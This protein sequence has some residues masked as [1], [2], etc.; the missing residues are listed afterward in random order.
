MHDE[1]TIL[2]IEPEAAPDARG[3]IWSLAQRF[4]LRQR[5]DVTL[6]SPPGLERLVCLLYPDDLEQR[7]AARERLWGQ[8]IIVIL[9]S[10]DAAVMKLDRMVRGD[11]RTI[12]GEDALHCPPDY[13]CADVWLKVFF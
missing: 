12:W 11:M 4:R 10:G 5:L 13:Q 6:N 2:I 9:F 3:I 7:Q 1:K 8:K